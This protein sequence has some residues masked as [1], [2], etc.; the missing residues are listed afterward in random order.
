M[1]CQNFLSLVQWKNGPNSFTD[2][3]GNLNE[4]QQDYLDEQKLLPLV[5]EVKKTAQACTA[6]TFSC[7]PV[8]NF[9]ADLSCR[10]SS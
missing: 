7:P 5:P 2:H 4:S 10:L 8:K 3:I 9:I 1:N 6:T